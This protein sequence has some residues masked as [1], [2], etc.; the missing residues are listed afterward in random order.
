MYG[1]DESTLLWYLSKLADVFLAP[2]KARRLSVVASYEK[3]TEAKSR[4]RRETASFAF[5]TLHSK[6][7]QLDQD[8]FFENGRV[9]L[10]QLDV[11]LQ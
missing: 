6:H 7:H 5:R 2:R 11:L 3:L 10:Q 4:K 9:R 1:N 8:F